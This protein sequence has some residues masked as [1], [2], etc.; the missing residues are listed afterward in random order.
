MVRSRLT[1]PC[2]RGLVADPLVV[3]ILPASPPVFSRPSRCREQDDDDTHEF[4]KTLAFDYIN[5]AE[6][7][8]VEIEEALCVRNLPTATSQSASIRLPFYWPSD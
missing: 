2:L 6:A 5:Q 4:S 3:M 7:T 8:F 1:P